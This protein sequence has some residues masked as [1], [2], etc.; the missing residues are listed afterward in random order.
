M[1][2]FGLAW[3]KHNIKRFVR[4]AQSIRRIRGVNASY[5]DVLEK[6]KRGFEWDS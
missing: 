1:M 2:N 3:L 6:A 4:R 5:N